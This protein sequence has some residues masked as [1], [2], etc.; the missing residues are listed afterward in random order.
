M[1]PEVLPTLKTSPPPVSTTREDP[2]VVTPKAAKT[3][4]APKSK[5]KAKRREKEEE[6][7]FILQLEVVEVSKRKASAWPSARI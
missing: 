2:E 7:S 6:E 5:A 4:P 1:S 3:G